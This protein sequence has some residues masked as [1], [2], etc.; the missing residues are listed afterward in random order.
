MQQPSVFHL[1]QID[2][3]SRELS[4]LKS[5]LLLISLLR[6]ISFAMLVA[7]IYYAVSTGHRVY[8]YAIGI[9]TIIFLILLRYFSDYRAKKSF[10]EQLHFINANER[11][12]VEKQTNEFD[13]GSE[14]AHDAIYAD[15]L[16][17]FGR[18]SLFHYLNRTTTLHGG[19][20]LAGILNHPP[21]SHHTIA[22]NQ[23]AVRQL[24]NQPE[25]MQHGLFSANV[26]VLM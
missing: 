23:E 1:E 20:A 25:K 7:M 14:Y 6:L 13:D 16:D 11:G 18:Q 9:T 5:R 17:I 22:L 8:F 15:D 12:I 21:Q 2:R 19:Q 4:K 3:Y 26:C 10:V 24:S